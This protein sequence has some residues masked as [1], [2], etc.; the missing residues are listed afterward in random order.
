MV[1]FRLLYYFYP[2][3][4]NKRNKRRFFRGARGRRGRVLFLL[5]DLSG[6]GVVAFFPC[7]A[8]AKWFSY[9]KVSVWKLA[10]LSSR[11]R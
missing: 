1:S 6:C 5:E 8:L 10:E 3:L 7:F 11:Y 2:D 4:A 9:I